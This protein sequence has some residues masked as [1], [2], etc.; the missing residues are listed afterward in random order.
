VGRHVLQIAGPNVPDRVLSA[1]DA[2]TI[3]QRGPAFAA[4]GRRL[5]EAIARL[6]LAGDARFATN[7]DQM[8]ARAD[9]VADDEAEIAAL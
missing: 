6:E 5:C 1:I 2:P 3:D 8:A 7:D 9:P 4:L